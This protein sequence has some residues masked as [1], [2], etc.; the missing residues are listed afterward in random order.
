LLPPVIEGG[1]FDYR[2]TGDAMPTVLKLAG[3]GGAHTWE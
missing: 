3:V 2:W 1:H